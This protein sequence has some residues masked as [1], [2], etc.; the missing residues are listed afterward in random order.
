MDL[1]NIGMME[2]GNKL[3]LALEACN[4]IGIMAQVG[5]QNLNRDQALQLG[6]ERLPDIALAAVG[7][8]LL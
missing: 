1:H 7:K 5:V 4:E 8:A 2:R 3:S 6:V